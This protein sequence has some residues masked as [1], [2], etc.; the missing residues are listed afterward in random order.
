MRALHGTTVVYKKLGAAYLSVGSYEY[1]I[2]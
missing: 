2:G 1:L